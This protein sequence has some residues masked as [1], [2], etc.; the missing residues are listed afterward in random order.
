MTVITEYNIK[1]DINH[2]SI[3]FT[4]TT[5]IKI[6]SLKSEIMGE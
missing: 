3:G 4:P 2:I 1:L 5:N 6:L